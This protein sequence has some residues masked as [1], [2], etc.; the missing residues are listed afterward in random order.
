VQI[1]AIPAAVQPFEIDGT[2]FYRSAYALKDDP[3]RSSG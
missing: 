2:R 1:E 3:G